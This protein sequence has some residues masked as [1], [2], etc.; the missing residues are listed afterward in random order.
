[1]FFP[2]VTEQLQPHDLAAMI[3]A[4]K[5]GRDNLLELTVD[6]ARNH[7]YI[8]FVP[9]LHSSVPPSASVFHMKVPVY[10]LQARLIHPLGQLP[11]LLGRGGRQRLIARRLKEH[12][13]TL[14]H[15]TIEVTTNDQNVGLAD[16][17]Q[18]L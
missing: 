7:E 2:R 10:D 12:L 4:I 14:S 18:K 3:A 16:P 17:I 6:F 13:C 15:M 11:S 8:V 9:L 1:M 5:S